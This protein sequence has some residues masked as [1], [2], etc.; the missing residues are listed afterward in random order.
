MIG[1]KTY[2]VSCIEQILQLKVCQQNVI[3]KKIE[4]NLT[5]PTILGPRIQHRYKT[6]WAGTE[7]R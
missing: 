2:S 7:K 4:Y 1:Q 6:L 3:L 5:F